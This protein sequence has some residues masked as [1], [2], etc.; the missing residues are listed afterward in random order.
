MHR[1]ITRDNNKQKQQEVGGRDS[2]DDARTFIALRRPSSKRDSRSL[3]LFQCSP[4]YL[5]R[6]EAGEGEEVKNRGVKEERRNAEVMEEKREGGRKQR[7][8]GRKKQNTERRKGR[9]KQQEKG[10]KEESNREGEK[11]K[12]VSRGKKIRKETGE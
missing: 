3:I 9:K 12:E 6:R 8:R 11:E 1:Y 5:R 7:R 10:G 2:D 4:L